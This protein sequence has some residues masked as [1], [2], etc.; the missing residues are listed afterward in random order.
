MRIS[1]RPQA[2][3]LVKA[4]TQCQGRWAKQVSDAG[5]SVWTPSDVRIIIKRKK[6]L[7]F[8]LVIMYFLY[9]EGNRRK[10]SFC[11]YNSDSNLLG[12]CVCFFL[13][14]LINRLNGTHPPLPQCPPSPAPGD[15]R[16]PSSPHPTGPPVCWP[17]GLGETQKI[18]TIRFSLWRV[19][20]NIVG[21]V[22]GFS[23]VRSSFI[24]TVDMSC[25]QTLQNFPDDRTYFVT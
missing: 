11:V 10:F 22:L 15:P 6:G 25:L 14:R 1:L 9:P 2:L 8:N 21:D 16:C 18:A 4:G 17:S 19:K 20:K 13:K 5:I 23:R 12:C 24:S 7:R 3:A